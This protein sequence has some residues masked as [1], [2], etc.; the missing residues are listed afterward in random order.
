MTLQEE[1]EEGDQGNPLAALASTDEQQQQ[2]QQADPSSSTDNPLLRKKVSWIITTDQE[3]S[4]TTQPRSCSL[5][6]KTRHVVASVIRVPW[7]RPPSQRQ[8][9][10]DTQ[11]HPHTNWGTCVVHTSRRKRDHDTVGIRL[12]HTRFYFLYDR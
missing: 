7:Y 5:P 11:M 1:E 10:G 8:R 6:R 12:T 4:N 9:W 2:Q 3:E